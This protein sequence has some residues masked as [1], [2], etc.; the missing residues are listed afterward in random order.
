MKKLSILAIIA[1]AACQ[2]ANAHIS[3]VNAPAADAAEEL[4]YTALPEGFPVI[5]E[6]DL[7][8]KSKGCG[9]SKINPTSVSGSRY[10]FTSAGKDA[11]GAPLYQLGVTGQLR[12]VIQTGA[13]DMAGEA[14]RY[15]KTVDGKEVEI[16]VS[17]KPDG[18]GHKGI[19]GRI[20]K[21]DEGVPLMCGY[22]RVEVAG[23][24]DL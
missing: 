17:I 7:P 3:V 20:K 24:C 11:S 4:D 14:V 23:D 13:D 2:A 8:H 5:A 15:F 19:V 16:L 1:L 22:N 21:W 12:T 10:V 6:I 9:L 18:D